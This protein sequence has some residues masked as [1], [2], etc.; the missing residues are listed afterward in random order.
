MMLEENDIR[1]VVLWDHARSNVGDVFSYDLADQVSGVQ[2][3]IP[4][5][6]DESIP[7]RTI[8]Y[9]ANG[10]RTSFSP[11][12]MTDTYTINDL[13]QYTSRD[14]INADYNFNGDLTTGVDGSAHTYDAQNRLLTASK[15]GVTY[16]FTYDGLNR[17]VGRTMGGGPTRYSV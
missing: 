17:Q 2:L 6:T 11:Y 15:D 9:D 1:S 7:P 5:P 16:N 8:I 4:N 12:G 10:N 3:D 13:S 14:T